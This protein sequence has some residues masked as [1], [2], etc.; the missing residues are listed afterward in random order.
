M[1]QSYKQKYHSVIWF[2]AKA[3]ENSVVN[4]IKW[5]KKLT[6]HLLIKKRVV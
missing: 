3:K 5:H 6:F 2:A 1:L 4:I